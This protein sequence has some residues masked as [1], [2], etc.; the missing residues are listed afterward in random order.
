LITCLIAVAFLFASL[1]SSTVSSPS[2]FFVF[3][4]FFCAAGGG[5]GIG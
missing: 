2:P 5:G 1:K 3:V 4:S